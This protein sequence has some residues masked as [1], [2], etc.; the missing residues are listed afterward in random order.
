M[1]ALLLH[2]SLIH[3]LST[4]LLLKLPTMATSC[5]AATAAAA[6]SPIIRDTMVI[7]TRVVVANAMKM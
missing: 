1:A 5:L 2:S 7:V 6:L 4:W 3:Y